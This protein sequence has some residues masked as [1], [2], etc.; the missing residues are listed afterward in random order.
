MFKKYLNNNFIKK[1]I[2]LNHSLVVSFILFT[3][4]SNKDLRFYVNYRVFNVIIIKNRYSLP[5][6]QKIL[7][8]IYKIRIY[9]IFDI[10]VVFNKL[11]IIEEKKWKTTYKTRYNLY[12]SF[13]INFNLCEISSS[14]QNYINNVLYEYFD[15]FYT[16]YIDDILI[17]NE[18]RKKHIRHVRLIFQRLKNVNFQI[19]IQKCSFEVIEIKYFD[20][21]IIINKVR[22]NMKKMIIVLNWSIS[23]NI[24]D[25]Q[26]F[27]SFVNFYRRFI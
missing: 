25:V 7:S 24:K 14:F 13:I 5:L 10:I 18:N 1:F 26:S 11:R 19:N 20:L 21:I 6:I 3:R 2:R 8:R 17:Y 12:E 15:D 4:K 27:L 22:M 16:I 23:K 9:I